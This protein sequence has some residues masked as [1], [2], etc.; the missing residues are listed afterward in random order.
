MHGDEVRPGKEMRGRRFS[1][2]ADGIDIVTPAFFAIA[3]HARPV[4]HDNIVAENARFSKH[5]FQS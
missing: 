3:F 1:A 5:V 4:S 2:A